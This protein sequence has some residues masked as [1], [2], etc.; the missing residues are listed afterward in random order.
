MAKVTIYGTQ[1]CGYCQSAERLLQ[2]KGVTDIAKIDVDQDQAAFKAMAERTGR[3]M[4]PQIFIGDLH[5][6]GFD[7]L[8]ALDRGGQLDKLLQQ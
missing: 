6:G 7:D 5:V 2:R 3:R 4:V 1:W 8:S